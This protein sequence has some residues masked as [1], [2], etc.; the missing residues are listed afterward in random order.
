MQQANDP[1]ASI[2]NVGRRTVVVDI[3][4]NPVDGDPPYKGMLSKGLC[5]VIG[6]EP[7]TDALAELNAKKGPQ[8]RYLPY[9]VGDGQP[10]TLHICQASGMT[11]LLEPD[12]R[13]LQNFPE[14]P[15]WGAVKQRES[16]STERLD[17]IAEITEMDFLKIDV[18]GAEMAVFRGGRTKLSKAV[19]VQT[20]VSFIPLYKN[21]PT[22]G[23]IDIALRGMGFVP[24]TFAALNHRMLHP[25]RGASPFDHLNQLLEA[26][27]VYVR[28]F[29]DMGSMSKEQLAHL[30]L[31]A[32]H[33]YSS[34][35]LAVRCLVQLADRGIVQGA[36][37]QQYASAI[38]SQ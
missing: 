28:D 14:F 4:A 32:H 25:L 27:I 15:T 34:F 26:D 19:A 5:D 11:S 17:D 10:H 13:A 38:R 2:L 22:F 35:D 18:Q 33:V 9:A 3:G 6:F 23:E 21:Q 1:L 7:Q 30:A 24:H 8:E 31:I 12:P 37:I 36:S 16:V 29:R 20:E